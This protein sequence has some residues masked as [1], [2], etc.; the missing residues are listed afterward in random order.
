MSD[1]D[2]DSDSLSSTGIPSDDVLEKGLRDIV[3][4]IFN[5]G[6]LEELTVKRVRSATEKALSLEEGFYKNDEVWKARSDQIIKQEAEKQEVL[7]A[8]KKKKP[9]PVAPKRA[10]PSKPQ[11]PKRSST[12][13][14]QP[15]RKRQRTAT[16]SESEEELSSL[17]SEESEEEEESPK[18]RKRAPP[19][20]KASKPV[21]QASKPAPPKTDTSSELS[22]V[23]DEPEEASEGAS[24]KGATP[25]GETSDTKHDE[26]ESEMSV[27]IDDEPQRKTKR[28]KSS[29]PSQQGKPKK[30]KPS[31]SSKPKDDADVDPDLAEIKKLQGQLV[32]CGIRKMWFRE[33]AQYDTP[34]A[35]VK[36]LR[37]MLK[38]A[39]MEGRFSLEKANAIREAR[40]LQ[41]DLEVVR[42]G[43]KRWG[44][45]VSDEEEAVDAGRP[46]R[47]VARG[48]Q[49]LSFLGDD[50]GEETD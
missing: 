27:L 35:K 23:P 47:R 14:S 31:S 5:K 34:R 28:R 44:T 16:P 11:A 41:A 46:R 2:S 33:L 39:G 17:P 10:P 29:E 40:E 26:S 24:L 42:E 3:A 9:T 32:K 20:K 7:I 13:A 48:F 22:D 36:H 30:P 43:A 8:K 6:N 45:N 25:K 15:S 4:G 12:A 19:A 50:D 37:Q 49:A 38:D 18:S 1:S 21:K